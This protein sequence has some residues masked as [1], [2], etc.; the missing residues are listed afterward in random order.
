[1]NAIKLNIKSNS[2]KAFSPDKKDK[3]EPKFNS[4]D[5]RVIKI[6][7]NKD[8]KI[9]STT[10]K[11]N[12]SSFK[13]KELT[14][15]TNF[16]LSNEFS[17]HR[18]RLYQSL[19]T[20]NK[21]LN[22]WNTESSSNNDNTFQKINIKPNLIHTI[23]DFSFKKYKPQ[24]YI[25]KEH[26]SYNINLI[27]TGEL[28]QISSLLSSFKSSKKHKK[29]KKLK[30]YLNTSEYNSIKYHLTKKAKLNDSQI[31]NRY[32]PIIK[33]FFLKKDYLRFEKK[34][35][36]FLHP[37]ELKMLYK[38]KS[39]INGIFEYLSKSF[40]KIR[41]NQAKKNN[42]MITDFFEKK[43]EESKNYYLKL[44]KEIKLPLDKLF[45]IKKIKFDSS[46][47]VLNTKN[48]IIKKENKNI[49]TKSSKELNNDLFP[50][51][52]IKI[53]RNNFF[54]NK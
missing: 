35:E 7:K 11:T 43:K 6:K 41:Y 22:N 40:M 42:K 10:N 13:P 47:K 8:S 1:M 31:L 4:C 24:N 39:L 20:N 54:N 16:T 18:S 26:N 36:K 19:L 37:N 15:S 52:Q 3:F 50:R 30:Y 23:S 2:L 17:N 49:M 34:S 32:R 29:K 27:N 5:K 46:D 9:Y 33:E 45:Q 51:F 14:L 38:E 28:T 44:E 48:K 12:Y 53:K 25:K 21:S